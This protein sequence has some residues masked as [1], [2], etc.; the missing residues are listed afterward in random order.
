MRAHPARIAS[1]L[2]ALFDLS[3]DES[4]QAYRRLR[5]A[6]ATQDERPSLAALDRHPRITAREVRQ[7]R[8]DL[9]KQEA[10]ALRTTLQRE[11]VEEPYVE[12]EFSADTEGAT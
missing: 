3:R 6:L 4:W 7:A 10:I 5:D 8:L 11:M 9:V 1:T 2:A 12:F